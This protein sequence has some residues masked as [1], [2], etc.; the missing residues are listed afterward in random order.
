[1]APACPG[2]QAMCMAGTHQRRT[3][4]ET[5]SHSSGPEPLGSS[6]RVV[7]AR[8]PAEPDT[9][10]EA[11]REELHSE[12]TLGWIIS[13]EGEGFLKEADLSRGL[14]DRQDLEWGENKEK[15]L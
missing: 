10:Q 8:S 13:D 6:W 11:L 5:V 2:H 4:P 14:K 15:A 9:I 1:M 3:G 12:S 7:P